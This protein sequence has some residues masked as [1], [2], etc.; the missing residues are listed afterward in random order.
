MGRYIASVSE[1]DNEQW[2]IKF[3]DR[4]NLFQVSSLKQRHFNAIRLTN[5][6]HNVLIRNSRK[7]PRVFSLIK[8]GFGFK[9]R[10]I[11]YICCKDN[12][13]LI[14]F[15]KQSVFQIESDTTL[16]DKVC[17]WLAAVLCFSL[18][19]R[20]SSTNKTDHHDVTE[21][22]LKV[23]LPPQ[24]ESA[25]VQLE[26]DKLIYIVHILRLFFWWYFHRQ[27]IL[28]RRYFTF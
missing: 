25:H 12:K 24:I 4:T 16:C 21:I 19:T 14:C 20:V 18:G 13:Y 15:T 3:P 2:Y 22:L 10:S 1:S 11:G 28:H 27:Y 7:M 9:N 6:V 8:K 5:Y 17:Q 26:I 23:A